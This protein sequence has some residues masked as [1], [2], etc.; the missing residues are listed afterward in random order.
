M[1][2]LQRLI[3]TFWQ[4]AERKLLFDELTHAMSNL[5]EVLRPF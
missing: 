3:N 2:V 1:T 4:G 5:L